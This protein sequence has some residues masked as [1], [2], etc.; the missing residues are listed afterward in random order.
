[1]Y[2]ATCRRP[3]FDEACAVHNH[4]LR[5][6]VLR[7]TQSIPAEEEM[8]FIYVCLWTEIYRPRDALPVSASQEVESVHG[9]WLYWAYST[10]EHTHYN[11]C[12]I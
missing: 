9:Y 7:R 10:S 6:T 12:S 5:F 3:G 4:I 2:C 8:I 11:Q 1:V